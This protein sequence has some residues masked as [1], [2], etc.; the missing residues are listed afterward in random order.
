LQPNETTRA[1][2]TIL[3]MLGFPNM[4]HQMQNGIFDWSM[5]GQANFNPI[6]GAVNAV[7]GKFHNNSAT[8]PEFWSKLQDLVSLKSA[9][10]TE[11]WEEIGEQLANNAMYFT[12]SLNQGQHNHN[13]AKRRARELQ[14]ALERAERL[15]R[16]NRNREWLTGLVNPSSEATPAEF[17]VAP[18]RMTVGQ[19]MVYERL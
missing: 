11:K 6:R 9:L 18:T 8:T 19:R 15:A 17:R 7:M 4:E 16:V 13:E 5:Q 14:E 2:A 1:I 3:D 12:N 10:S